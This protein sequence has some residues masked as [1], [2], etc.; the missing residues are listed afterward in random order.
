MAETESTTQKPP[1][2]E[3]ASPVDHPRP[4][5][6]L[7]E[8]NLAALLGTPSASPKTGSPKAAPPPPSVNV[9]SSLA[10]LATAQENQADQ[11]PPAAETRK[12]VTGQA[13]ADNADNARALL[14]AIQGNRAAL[15]RPEAAA[16]PVAPPA[17]AAKPVVAAIASQPASEAPP[18]SKVR[19]SAPAKTV[20]PSISERIAPPVPAGIDRSV[21]TITESKSAFPQSRNTLFPSQA[22][23]PRFMEAGEP[24]PSWL[25]NALDKLPGGRRTLLIIGAVIAVGGISAGL[26]LRNHQP[27]KPKAASVAVPPAAAAVN[28]FPLQLQVEPQGNG[29][30]NVRWNPQSTLVT[31]AREG[32]LVIT[33]VNQKPTTIALPLEQLK[34]GHLSYPSHAE[35]VEFRLEVTDTSGA[36]AEESVL[37]LALPTTAKPAAATPQ[38]A[39]ATNVAGVK[40]D[41]SAKAAET[42]L[43]S[44]PAAR[45]FTPPS[46]Q[47]TPEQRAIVDAPPALPNAPVAAPL[48]GSQAPAAAPPPPPLPAPVRENSVISPIQV[49]GNLQASKLVTRITPTY[50]PLAKSA[51]VQGTVR[52]KVVVGANG[53][54]QNLEVIGGPPLLRPAATD[55]VKRWVYR[56][57]LVNGQPVEVVTQ[58]DVAFTLN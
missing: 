50:P 19:V 34:F 8:E 16:T 10:L 45:A 49:P 9:E 18:A 28:N 52:L 57:T 33:E 3:P 25:A 46:L 41:P 17:P 30:I 38:P 54:V 13:P 36:V 4:S 29:Q 20:A 26:V 58:I 22:P 53:T 47:R 37:A 56:P 14:T 44:R 12:P 39:T 27:A 15:P 23:L 24:A 51:H 31:Q 48:V 35:R 21:P 7:S 43:S 6:A 1:G 55:A 42:P 2:V 32:R 40:T 5:V 11:P